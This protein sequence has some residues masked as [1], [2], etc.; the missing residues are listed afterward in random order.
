[1]T[2]LKDSVKLKDFYQNAANIDIPCHPDLFVPDAWTKVLATGIHQLTLK[3]KTV[4]EVGTGIGVNAAGLMT[5][6]NAPAHYIGTDLRDEAI[7]I[8]R[9]LA[10]DLNLSAEF[11]KSNLLKSI[12]QKKL[13][14]IDNIFACI[15]QVP[16]TTINLKEK[17]NSAHYYIADGNKWDKY[18]YGLNANLI[19]Q[20]PDYIDLT[21]NLCG[22][23]GH[24]IHQKLFSE[25]GRTA[26]ILHSAIIPQHLNTSLESFSLMEKNGHED[27]EFFSDSNGKYLLTAMQAEEKRL[28]ALEKN[29][30]NGEIYHKIYVVHS[31]SLTPKK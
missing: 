25:F 27:F 17:D 20:T 8:S 14:T 24:A 18:G 29:E 12:S 21:L 28:E 3:N 1:M 22:R 2:S 11:I 19:E 15:P 31:P 26:T 7:E 5:S 10:K 30:I 23:P 4:L 6:A 13:K 16:S 9:A